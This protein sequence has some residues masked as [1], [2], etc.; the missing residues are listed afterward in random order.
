MES[1]ASNGMGWN[2]MG[3]QE[4][5]SL[6]KVPSIIVLPLQSMQLC[7]NFWRIF[8]IRSKFIMAQLVS[9]EKRR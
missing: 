3:R 4:L 9:S 6:P 8:L 2:G 7:R 1:V 5:L